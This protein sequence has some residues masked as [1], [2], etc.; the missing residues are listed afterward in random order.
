VE[1]IEFVE[2]VV[3]KI[4]CQETVRQFLEVSDNVTTHGM[5]LP[6]FDNPSI[7]RET[8]VRG[9]DRNL[10]KGLVMSEG[11]CLTRIL[12]NKLHT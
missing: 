8:A 1:I 5:Q 4:A 9:C 12:Q 6:Y 11:D 7:E 2:E 3:G 10:F